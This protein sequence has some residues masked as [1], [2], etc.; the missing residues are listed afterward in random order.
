[1]TAR[2]TTIRRAG[3]R[4]IAVAGFAIAAWFAGVVVVHAAPLGG[5]AA[6]TPA[7]RDRVG[8]PDLITTLLGL[9]PG[10]SDADRVRP[11]VMGAD[12]ILL[13]VLTPAVT[14]LPV[15]MHHVVRHER[16]FGSRAPAAV[17]Y[18]LIQAAEYA[19]AV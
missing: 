15:G 17:A 16:G 2:Q 4:A 18:A 9:P 11:V 13:S 7:A 10:I 5:S 6:G 3:T 8:A 1:M 12:A 14:A 19:R